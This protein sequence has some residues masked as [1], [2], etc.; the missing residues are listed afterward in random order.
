MK[1]ENNILKYYLRNVYFITGTA[2]AG[3]STMVKMLSERYDMVR[4][5]ENF[6]TPVSFLT[7]R[8]INTSLHGDRSFTDL[9]GSYAAP[10]FRRTTNTVFAKIFI[11]WSMDQFFM[12]SASSLTTSSKSTILLLPLICHRPVMPGL[13]AILSL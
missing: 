13:I 8:T 5:G 4:C 7:F 6:H 2:Y 3:K 12:Y 11:S 1:I 9:P 10:S